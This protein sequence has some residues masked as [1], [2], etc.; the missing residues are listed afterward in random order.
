MLFNL[1]N[2]KEILVFLCIGIYD[3]GV[4]LT[5][6]GFRHTCTGSRG[7]S[8]AAIWNHVGK[9]IVRPLLFFKHLFFSGS[10]FLIFLLSSSDESCL[11]RQQRPFH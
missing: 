7:L 1:V 10:A 11:D 3:G 6:S 9:S 2:N 4:C 8:T 5:V